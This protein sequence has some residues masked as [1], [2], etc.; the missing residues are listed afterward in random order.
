MTATWPEGIYIAWQARLRGRGRK[1]NVQMKKVQVTFPTA[2]LSLDNSGTLTHTDYVSLITTPDE[3]VNVLLAAYKKRIPVEVVDEDGKLLSRDDLI[4]WEEFRNRYFDEGFCEHEK[5]TAI[6][7]AAAE[8]AEEKYEF[9]RHSRSGEVYAVK[10]V[11][12]KVASA[13]GPLSQ[14]EMRTVPLPDFDFANPDAVK[15][16]AWI[17][18]NRLDFSR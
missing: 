10:V 6:L 3:A 11:G 15:D 9:W 12:G 17:E 7:E 4:P 8:K 13:V 18:Q 5:S 14:K 1:E 16:G 2:M